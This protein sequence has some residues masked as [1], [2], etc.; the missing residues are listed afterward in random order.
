MASLSTV[1]GGIFCSE[2]GIEVVEWQ[3]LNV[4][5]G[6]LVAPGRAVKLSSDLVRGEVMRCLARLA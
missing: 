4:G 6:F 5:Q 2:G 1:G 3:K